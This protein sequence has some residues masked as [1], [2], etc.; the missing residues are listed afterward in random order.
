MKN[1]FTLIFT[2]ALFAGIFVYF[3]FRNTE[4]HSYQVFA[5]F[6]KASVPA[7]EWFEKQ[8]AFPFDEIP[9]QEYLK[10]VE[11][12]N[13][14]M[15]TLPL[16]GSDAVPQWQLAGPTNIEGRVTT[17]AIHPQTLQTVYIGTANGGVWKSTNFCQT[18]TSV[19]NNQN[20]SSIGTLAIDPVNGNVI[21]CGTG[22]ANSL[23]SYYPGTG[24]YK[25]TDAGNTW[26]FSG[27]DS[28]YCFGNIT[29]NPVN[30]Q[31]I[32]AAALGST[33]RKNDQRGIYRSSN[34]GTSWERKLFIADSVGAIDVVVDPANP[35]KVIAAMWE[36]QRRE[37][38]IKYGGRNS[39]IYISTNSGD[40]WA[41]P[42]GGFPMNDVNL[43]RVS[44]DISRSNP[45]V[46]Y[47]LAAATSGSSRGLYKTTNGGTN[48]TQINASA[49]PS[50]N[51]A[52]F[53]RICKVS[54]TN[55][56][57]VFAGGLEMSL[58]NNGGTSLT[59]VATS[60]V[61][62]HAVAFAPSN[63]DFIVIGNDGGI[64]YSINGGSTWQYSTTLPVT[65]FYAGE[66]DYNDPNTILG[67]TQDNGTVRTT[68]SVGSWNEIYGGD[69]FYCLV[70]YVNPQNV[71]ASS[72]TGGIGRSVDG[73]QS[74]NSGT[75]GLDLTYTNW[76]T[77]YVMDKNN[78]QVLYCGTYKI[79]KTTNGMQSW[80]SISPDL[81]NRHVANLGTI[82]T[83]D[84]AKSNPNVIYCG[85]DDAN[86]WVTTNS[87][88]NWSKI[89][90]GLPYRWVTRVA[91]HPDSANVCYVT[92]SGYKVD[93]TGSHIFRT[94][95]Y[96]SS[97]NSIRGNLPDAPINDVVIDPV[98]TNTL[99]IGTDITVMYTTDLGANWYLLGNG[100][101]SNVPCHDLTLH[102][103]SRSLVV[104][105]HGRSAFRTSLP[106][107]ELNESNISIPESAE[108]YQNF[109]NP[110]NPM[111]KIG[112]S[113]KSSGFVALKIHDITGR[114]AS[115]L[116]NERQEAGV[117]S[118]EFNA[119]NLPSGIYFYS[120]YIDGKEF[121][122]KKMTLIK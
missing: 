88:T 109:P 7:D 14:N 83:V 37:D 53:N 22:E 21:Y 78:P 106:I 105:T 31:I 52:W 32:Y 80:T 39:G 97:W 66:I 70:D 73:G 90:A 6:T 60:H 113:L 42:G 76:M 3:V 17:I 44:L 63:S 81:A 79:H 84:A 27:L 111:T 30:T 36:R 4:D 38:Y 67:G 5:D 120:L 91:V 50:S 117:Y 69:G 51:Y 121:A 59:T 89:N 107:T 8:R 57:K 24:I 15:Q 26:N 10:S 118:S 114:L 116:V 95:N 47:A 16:P 61:D 2:L 40:T 19:F 56:D 25:S 20:T 112:Y 77:P 72:Q 68:G 65:Q 98:N 43:G 62:Q 101:P 28:S 49:A 13:N 102:N 41:Q 9:Q 1:L 92:L 75:T 100:I 33:R 85:T 18:W 93:S 87:G 82:T 86:V 94:T 11:Y 103:P 108:L 55:A 29:I 46:I 45:Q 35:T 23:R 54:P 64:D 58:S 115:E 34:G 110:F 99:Y 119:V 74:F 122:T 48:W 71:Y 96:G 104:W 12:V